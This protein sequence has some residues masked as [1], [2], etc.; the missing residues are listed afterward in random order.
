MALAVNDN[1]DRF[2]GES[3]Q[4]TTASPTIFFKNQMLKKVHQLTETG[5]RYC[6]MM[7]CSDIFS[8]ELILRKYIPLATFN[9][10]SNS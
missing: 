10:I 4:S 2:T 1:E 7:L 9:G 6:L 3:A 8:S 5:Y